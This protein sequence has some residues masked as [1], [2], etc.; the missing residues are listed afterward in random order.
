[1]RFAFIRA[2]KAQY[3]VRVLC[4][5]LEVSPS[6]YYAWLSRKPSLRSRETTKLKVTIRALFAE[7]KRRYGSPRIWDDLREQGWIVGKNRVARLMH[8][9][10][11]QA[12]RKRRF[13]TTTHSEHALVRFE[14]VLSRDFQPGRL[15]E[16]WAGDIT[17]LPTTRGWLYLAVL[18]DLH[19]RR[20]VG[21]SAS[22][23][24]DTELVRQALEQA[25]RARPAP[26]LHH[27]DQ[28]CQYAADA[29][30]AVLRRHGIEASMSRRGNCWDNAPVES[31]FSTLKSELA[32]PAHGWSPER[33]R[34][35]VHDYLHWYNHRRKHSAL[36]FR[37]PADFE[38]LSAA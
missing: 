28:G 32:M 21:A 27:S 23:R 37:R 8:D 5:V 22:D 14:N 7:N 15:N 33:T 1:M 31:F 2:E 3:P 18:L 29:Y 4:R 30:Q 24:I 16:V 19:S 34:T 6:G 9:M 12:R 10:E 11:L 13:V 35:H 17:Y 38:R 25:L 20:V 26:A 36:G